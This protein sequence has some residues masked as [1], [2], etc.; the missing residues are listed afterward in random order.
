MAPQKSNARTD[1]WT[2]AQVIL[3]SVQCYA[4]HWINNNLYRSLQIV[5]DS[6]QK[7]LANY[8]LRYCFRAFLSY[9]L[10]VMPG[11]SKVNFWEQFK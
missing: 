4:L 10:Y 6:N 7:S 5:K 3:Y 2:D 9:S 8:N 11:P 1:G